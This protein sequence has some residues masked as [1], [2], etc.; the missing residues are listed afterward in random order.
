MLLL[1]PLVPGKTDS[2]TQ[3]LP[4]VKSPI[5]GTIR[6]PPLYRGSWWKKKHAA[7]RANHVNSNSKSFN[8]ANTSV[9][10]SADNIIIIII[11][12]II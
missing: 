12:I 8:H 1:L 2:F 11:I 7:G 3:H 5:Y 9:L 6:N 10:N 4:T